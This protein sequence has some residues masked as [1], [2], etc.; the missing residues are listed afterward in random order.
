[1]PFIKKLVIHGFKSFANKTE[2]PLE[3]SMN[4]VVGPNGSGKSNITD[5]LCFAL[6][7]ISIKSIR[8]AKAANL[9]FSGNKVKKPSYEA[10]VEIVFDNSNKIFAVDSNDVSLKRI[11]RRN[12]QSI[13]KINH[14]TKT[15][16]ELLEMLAQ[17][18]IDPHGFNIVLQGEIASLIKITSDERRK[19]IEEVS[20][21][22]IYETRKQKSLKEMEKTEEKLKE[23]DAILREKN[24]YLRNLEKE[25]Q[26]ALNYQRLEETIKR[27]KA[28]LIFKDL[29]EKD[30]EILQI[31]KMI[32]EHN[33]KIAKI[34]KDIDG[35]AAEINK[36]EEELV[37]INKFIQSATSN[38]QEQIYREV[39]ELKAKITGFEVREEN[40]ENRILAN[41][42]K[43]QKVEEKIEE[44]KREVS[45]MKVSSP[46]IKEQQEKIKS[47]QEKF[48][49]LEKDRRKFY[50]IKS[51]LST[52]ENKRTEKNRLVIESKKE[53]EL[54]ERN[55]SLLSEEIKYAKSF[56]KANALIEKT[57]PEIIAFGEK[58]EKLEKQEIEIE[59]Q[60]AA[61]NQDRFREEKLIKDI[62]KIDVCPLCKN[63]VIGEHVKEVVS[64]SQKKIDDCK[65]KQE[66]NE[67]QKIFLIKERSDTKNN[68]S[69]FETK[70]N[71][72]EIDI[73]KLKSADE[74]KEQLKKLSENQKKFNEEL[75]EINS[76]LNSLKKDYEKLRNVEE[77][78]DEVRLKIQDASLYDIDVDTEINVKQRELNRLNVEIKSVVRDSEDSSAQLKIILE[79]LGENRKI[80]EMKEKEEQELYEKFQKFFNDRNALQDKQKA[81]ETLIMGMQHEYQNHER[82]MGDLRISKAKFEGEKESLEFNSKEFD[83]MEAFNLPEEQIKEK[84]V[85]SQEKILRIGSVNLRS[86]EVYDGVKELCVGIEQ[87][88]ETIQKE[89]DQIYKIIEEIDRKKKKSFMKTLLAVNEYF[90]RNFSQLS[91]KGEVFL[92]LENK[93]DPFAGG[94]NIIVKVGH[95]KYFDVTSLSGGEKTLIALSLIFAIQEYKPYCFYVF[96]EIDAALDKHNSEK[97]AAL[98]KRY[99]VSGQ[100]IVVTH[101]D[102]LISEASS[103]YGISMQEN[104]SKVISLKI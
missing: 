73:M 89:K 32:E 60:N 68:L 94:L 74:K 63:K 22:S 92:D 35:K 24:A 96:D 17:A 31:D 54:I 79:G 90:T 19:I 21:I 36:L 72:I 64:N 6:G 101:N 8:A 13:Y 15:R 3:N 85:R 83:G 58:I 102:A 38:E 99:M 59:K 40:F 2:I 12:G 20:G 97:L 51:E 7:R 47:Y 16:Q 50:M 37:K 77:D 25:R 53:L 78:Y 56:E 66:E 30:K 57:K 104:I 41:E 34:K 39:S 10:F 65:T 46:E 70:L 5:A 27:C 28:S 61:M 95:G 55:I 14:K 45:E 42:E 33:N 76:K 80:L 103:L 9:I 88:V 43:K 81:V 44:L 48:D 71:E 26:E 69:L 98:I 84:L 52:L 86:L 4:V 67:K 49:I 1:M 100:Y 62:T 75:E 11:V 91:R 18:G 29:K 93:K 23:V 87:K 82:Q